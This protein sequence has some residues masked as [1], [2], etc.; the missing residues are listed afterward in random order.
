M[1]HATSDNNSKVNHILKITESS[2][3]DNVHYSKPDFGNN[4]TNNL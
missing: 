2:T 4:K 3:S 1:F